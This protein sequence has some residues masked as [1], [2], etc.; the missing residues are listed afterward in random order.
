ML[1]LI[2]KKTNMFTTRILRSHTSAETKIPV[3]TQRVSNSGIHPVADMTAHSYSDMAASRSP[4]PKPEEKLAKSQTGNAK[5]L[6]PNNDSSSESE[7]DQDQG[8]PWTMV[9]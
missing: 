2:Y 9:Q 6:N 4:S 8:G 5:A 3:P 7:S 1:K